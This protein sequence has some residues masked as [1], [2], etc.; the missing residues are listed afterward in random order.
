[1]ER[2]DQRESSA[3]Q[4]LMANLMAS[5]KSELIRVL[6]KSLVSCFLWNCRVFASFWLHLSWVCRR[7]ILVKW[8]FV[9]FKPAKTLE[10][11]F[12]FHH[13][14]IELKLTHFTHFPAKHSENCSNI[15]PTRLVSRETPIRVS[16]GA[17]IPK[18][19]ALQGVLLALLLPKFPLDSFMLP[20]RA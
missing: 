7:K 9:D 1:M 4:Q 6:W 2:E 11:L 16:S 20:S 17:N 12:G 15:H 13:H 8:N 10:N 5:D 14:R 18:N 19:P 3:A